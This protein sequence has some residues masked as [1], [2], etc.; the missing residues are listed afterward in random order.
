MSVEGVLGRLGRG[1]VLHLN[2][3]LELVVLGEGDDFEDGPVSIKYLVDGVQ[4]DAVQHV[5][6]HGAQN[7]ILTAGLGRL[8]QVLGKVESGSG[9][10]IVGVAGIGDQVLVVR[11]LNEYLST[12]HTDRIVDEVVYHGLGLFT[13]LELEE[14]LALAPQVQ[15]VLDVAEDQAEL[16]DLNF[17]DLLRDVADVDD[18]GGLRLL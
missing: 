18:F 11:V 3:R 12:G 13:L 17:G 1:S 8:V 2:Q 9:N 6:Y 4:T 16:N 15:D 10:L 7:G 5:L 14:G